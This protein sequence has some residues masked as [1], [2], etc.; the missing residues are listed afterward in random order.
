MLIRIVCVSQ[1]QFGIPEKSSSAVILEVPLEQRR[2]LMN[3]PIFTNTVRIRNVDSLTRW[4]RR[5]LLYAVFVS[6]NT[7]E[8]QTR[9]MSLVEI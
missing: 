6:K 1:F 2:F 4:Y 5:S 8:L 7:P 3:P 9:E